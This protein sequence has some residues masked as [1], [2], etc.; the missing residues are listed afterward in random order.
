MDDKTALLGYNMLFKFVKSLP[1][2]LAKRKRLISFIKSGLLHMQ[3]VSY[4][5][6]GAGKTRK[7]CAIL[8]LVCDSKMKHKS[9][10]DTL[11]YRLTGFMD[12]YI[13]LYC[14][15]QHNVRFAILNR[16]LYPNKMLN[17]R[18]RG[19]YIVLKASEMR[20]CM[21]QCRYLG[22]Y[23]TTTRTPLSEPK[24]CARPFHLGL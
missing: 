24:H 12:S 9:K 4:E 3:P 15:A 13:I 6:S 22:S 18:L 10:T 23:R 21:F 14:T 11:L 1:E 16:V 17:P 8:N 19:L 7:K 20:P 5:S 2:S